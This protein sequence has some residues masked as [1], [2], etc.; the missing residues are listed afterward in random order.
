MNN[1][2]D[3]VAEP[4]CSESVVIPSPSPPAGSPSMKNEGL[5]AVYVG[6]AIAIL[7]AIVI[8]VVICVIVVVKKGRAPRS[9]EKVEENPTDER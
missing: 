3:L 6:V 2:E 8:T 4:E 5:T 7:S 1:L 9:E